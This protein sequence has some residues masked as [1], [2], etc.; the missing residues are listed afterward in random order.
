MSHK[1]DATLLD[2]GNSIIVSYNNV[3]RTHAGRITTN[4]QVLFP[5]PLPKILFNLRCRIIQYLFW[6]YFNIL[7]VYIISIELNSQKLKPKIFFFF[8]VLGI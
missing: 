8:F 5:D 7:M 2:I 6:K 1:Y 3:I 4:R